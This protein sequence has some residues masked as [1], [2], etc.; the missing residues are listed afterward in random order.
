VTFPLTA[1]A[2]YALARYLYDSHAAALIAGLVFAFSPVRMAQ[3]AYHA[4]LVQTQWLPL[5]LLALVALVDRLTV[6]R[7][8]ALAVTLT[9][10]ALA[11]DYAALI[12]VLVSPVVIGAFWIIRPDANRNLRPLLGPA[13]VFAMV[14]L[15][16]GYVMISRQIG[17]FGAPAAAYPIDEVGYYRA[18]WWAYLTPS[19]DHPL[20]GRLAEGIVYGRG[21]NMELLEQQVYVGFGFLTL[22]LFA[23]VMAAAKWQTRWR[24]VAA[25]AAVGAV[26]LLISMAPLSGTC[27][28][29]S[30][31]P[32]CL[33][34]H[35]L[36]VLR[37]YG[38]FS[39]AVSLAVALAAGAGAVLLARMSSIGRY[40]AGA[41]LVA[42][43]LEYSPL[44]ARAHDVLPSAA[45]RWIANQPSA[46]AI[47]CFPSGGSEDQ[48]PWLTGRPL[49]LLNDDI[50]SCSEPEI[51]G[52]LVAHGYT[53]VIERVRIATTPLPQ[54]LPQGLTLVRE[55]PDSK[56]Y[57]VSGTPPPVVTV[58]TSG[59]YGAE[60]TGD[61]WWRWMSP[62]GRQ[63]VKNT[64][65][66]P[67][68]VRFA[69]EL[70]SVGDPRTLTM[71]VDGTLVTTIPVGLEKRAHDLGP[72]TFT[73]GEHVVAFTADGPPLRPSDVEES[74]DRRLLTVAF[75][76]ERWVVVK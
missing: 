51:V 71:S 67:V 29:A 31:A 35:W 46:R 72:V 69:V 39:M 66:S 52:E 24:N 53:H 16:G 68:T 14:L 26:A 56:V 73:P 65:A 59:F 25:V 15:A 70:I 61:D 3:A 37:V 57:A 27:G 64:T 6:W 30:L 5:Y 13:I 19:I 62:A 11:N 47:D 34:Y 20:F 60:H 33:M 41:L 1:M 4:D 74:K 21:I 44:P 17:P 8:I 54:P 2:T 42:G 18:R 10:V 40:A 22:A 55:F 7:A 43:V 45:H 32:G 58:A 38:R 49:S 28:S 63:T 48:V 12:A 9:A 76:N 75:H 50:S 36:P 23:F